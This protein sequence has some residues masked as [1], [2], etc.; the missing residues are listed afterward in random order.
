MDAQAPTQLARE[1]AGD[2]ELLALLEEGLARRPPDD[3]RAEE[4]AAGDHGHEHVE[5]RPLAVD[6]PGVVAGDEQEGRGEEEEPDGAEQRALLAGHADDLGGGGIVEVFGGVDERLW[7]FLRAVH[8]RHRGRRASAL[9]G[10][11]QEQR[12]RRAS[13]QGVGVAHAQALA[14]EGSGDGGDEGDGEDDELPCPRRQREDDVVLADEVDADGDADDDGDGAEGDDD[15]AAAVGVEGDAAG[16]AVGEAI[17]VDVGLL[18]ER[19]EPNIVVLHAASVR[20]VVAYGASRA[21]SFSL[22]RAT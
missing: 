8:R 9:E 13:E 16:D 7:F 14:R 20:G 10:L 6:D 19:V 15:A 2:A 17:V 22:P 11:G 18:Q 12:R 4:E 21:R 5:E 3:G 1:A